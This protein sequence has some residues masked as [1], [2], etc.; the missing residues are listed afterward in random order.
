MTGLGTVV[1]SGVR[2]RRVQTVVIALA[3]FLAVTA[4]VLAG[5]LLV[6][7]TAPFDRSFAAQHGAHLS[8]LFDGAR[9]SE[10]Q[11][12]A[13]AHAPGVAEA[14]GPFAVVTQTPSLGPD[15]ETP[16]GM[17]LPPLTIVGRAEPTRG[18]DRVALVEGRW[19]TGPGEIVLAEGAPVGTRL[20]FADLPGRPAVTVVGRARSTS[21]TAEAW[22]VPTAIPGLTSPGATPGRQM[23]YRLAAHGSTSDVATGLAAVTSTVPG[24]ALLGSRSWLASKEAADRNTALFVPLLVAFGLLGL[25]MAVLSVGGVVAGA[26]GAATY[27][28]GVLRALGF[29]PGQVVRAYLGQALIPAAVGIGLG[30]VAGNLLAVPILTTT[31]EVYGTGPSGVAPWVDVVVVAAAV[32][33][34]AATAWLAS[35]R[36]GRLRPVEA[37]TV[38]RA[39]AVGR[40]RSAAALAARLPLPRPISLGLAQPFARPARLT[41]MIAT[42]VFGTAAV[43]LAVGLAASLNRIEAAR[44]HDTADVAVGPS[45]PPGQPG[46]GPKAGP[47]SRPEPGP[48]AATVRAAIAAR[49]GTG[50]AYGIA[51]TTAAVAGVPG[52][53]EVL[54]F[55]DDPSWAGY[56]LTEGRWF[57][58]PGE[59][60]VPTPLL[61]AVGAKVGDTISLSV[62]GRPVPVRVVGEVFSTSNEGMQVFTR[63]D[64]MLAAEPGLRPR[65]YRVDV[66][67][68]VDVAGYVAALDA[69]VRPLGLRAE[70]N[71][72]GQ[73]EVL[74]ALGA[75]TGLLT[76]M[77]V[78]VAGLGILNAVVLQTRER[79]RE[80]GVHKALGMTPRQAVAVVLSSVVLFGLVGGALGVPAGISLHGVL[81][82]AMGHRA[83]VNLPQVVLDVYRPW[84]VALLGLGGLVIAVL[85]AL[86][87]AL[88]AARIRTATA[89]RTE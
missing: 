63:L 62:D 84:S 44:T 22:V 76:L 19:A 36:A 56:E 32:A 74:L 30:V 35:W 3:A 41:T 64:T 73:S 1:R 26:V 80:L 59:V 61:T 68:G 28:I 55:T 54:A 2:R 24:G 14:A 5:S 65:E 7:S 10:A 25:V 88:W 86:L 47:G 18:V 57:R 87:P 23:L 66:A 83:G 51:E 34:V 37:L 33:V 4:A 58:D 69:A 81:L 70:V 60:L 12:A 43:A 67:D 20:V 27:R 52:A 15:A 85:G 40:G 6:A 11:V 17:E 45:R 89:L 79:V 48:D 29:T 16:A 39:P 21:Q 75:L 46:P 38:G 78:A 71:R 49:P 72:A 53:V 31:S 42:V 50:A 82:P 77:L 9:A 13:S 8:A